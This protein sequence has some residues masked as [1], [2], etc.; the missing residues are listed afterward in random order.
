MIT[1][2]LYRYVYI[3][4]Y[5]AIIV[6]SVVK[7]YKK[8]HSVPKKRV[9]RPLFEG[10][11]PGDE[12]F[13]MAV[14]TSRMTHPAFQTPENSAYNR[15]PMNVFVG[16]TSSGKNMLGRLDMASSSSENA[17]SATKEMTLERHRELDRVIKKFAEDKQSEDAVKEQAEMMG[18]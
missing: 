7:I 6:T 14:G 9:N 8:V 11:E 15:K 1:S 18:F 17:P 4:T 13:I 2:K 5:I 3:A 12:R 16:N 10:I